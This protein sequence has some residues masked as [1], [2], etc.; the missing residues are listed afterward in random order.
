MAPE[1][2]STTSHVTGTD[3]AGRAHTVRITRSGA[4]RA[5]HCETCGWSQRAQFLPWL[6][7][8]DHLAEA[9]AAKAAAE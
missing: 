5:L 4:A 7:A 8:R 3:T 9:H 2:S 6:K 1:D